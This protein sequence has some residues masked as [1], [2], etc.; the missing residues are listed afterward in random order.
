MFRR[1]RSILKAQNIKHT[2][3]KEQN[4]SSLLYLVLQDI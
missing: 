4:D 3:Y 1:L 2:G